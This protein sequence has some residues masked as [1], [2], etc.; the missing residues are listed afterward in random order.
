MI[1][2]DASCLYE[3][4]AGTPDAEPIR[5]HFASDTDHAAPHVIDVEV[6]S[7]I[8]RSYLAGLLDTTAAN[9]AIEDLRDWPGERF[10]HRALLGRAWELRHNVRGWDAMY[11]ALAEML[12]ATLLTSDKRLGGVQGISCPVEVV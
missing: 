8:R 3:V 11:I 6:M 1:V 2:I 4:V 5:R 12:H 7:V 10:G 9:Q